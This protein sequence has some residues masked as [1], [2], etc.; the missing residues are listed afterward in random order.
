MDGFFN[1][2][3]NKSMASFLS[4]CGKKADRKKHWGK[5]ETEERDSE[6]N[7][8]K[9]EEKELTYQATLDQA[10][11]MVR[12]AMSNKKISTAMIMTMASRYASTPQNLSEEER[13]YYLR[14]FL[15]SINPAQQ[16]GTGLF[17]LMFLI[18]DKINDIP[19]WFYLD[20]PYCK[21]IHIAKPNKFF[22]E[23]FIDSR[24]SLFGGDSINQDNLDKYKEKFISL[25][26]GFTNIELNGL[27]ILCK[28]EN[29][30]IEHIDKAI[31]LF[32]YGIKENPWGEIGKD[33]LNSAE[34]IIKQRVKGQ[35]QAISQTL[36]I[37]KRA[38]SGMSG[39]QHSSSHSAPKGI[40]FFAGPTGTGKTELAKALAEGLF[41]SEDT[42]LRFDMS[43]YQQ[44]HSDQKLLGAPPGY[45]GYEAG[46]QLTNAIKDNPFSILLFDEIEKA[47]PSIL[48]KFLQILEDGRM[49]DGH[50]ETVYFSEAII[51]FTSNL[52]IYTKDEY[53]NRKKNIYFNEDYNELSKKINKGIEDYFHLELGRPEILNRIGN[54]FVIFNYLNKETA[55]RILDYQKEK[56][57]KRIAQ[58][59]NI[60]I[61]MNDNACLNLFNKAYENQEYGGRGIGNAVEHYL[62][63][64]L[65]RFLHDNNV[66][67]DSSLTIVDIVENN[68]IVELVIEV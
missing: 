39:L 66:A 12:E 41:G 38:A 23:H 48:D 61:L 60:T 33:K 43:E 8:E 57:F 2:Y 19:A 59:K 49:T 3:D 9:Y 56:I 6:K 37:I 44:S 25:T 10:T 1:P 24:I 27:G 42:C 62:I 54:N 52:G 5:K 11:I 4:L 64:P 34:K 13:Q 20:N 7:C 45:V 14:F 40:L 35:H 68:D 53:G 29:I 31:A 55:E 21:N 67:E 46:G 65:S 18:C 50:G 16:Y 51:I 15:T 63:N 36:D 26:D 22:R 17:N 47:H 32:K 28:Q 58:E 30:T